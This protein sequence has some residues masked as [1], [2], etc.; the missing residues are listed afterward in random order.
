MIGGFITINRK[1]TEWQWYKYPVHSRLFIHCLLKANF[2][3]NKLG[4]KIIKRGSFVTSCEILA[5]ELGYTKKTVL[6]A[7]VDLEVSGELK[8][9]TCNKGTTITIC[10]YSDYQEGGV[11]ITPQSTPQSTPPRK[12]QVPTNNNVNKE[13]KKTKEYNKNFIALFKDEEIISW[14]KETG[15]KKIHDALLD[16]YNNDFL[17]E[18][19]A[20]A[21]Y[22]QLE[23]KKRKAGTFLKGWCERSNN[24]N[25]HDAEKRLKEFDE[26]LIR[27]LDSGGFNVCE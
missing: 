22:W 27:K 13:T 3:D 20:N 7:L 21:Y 26:E 6:R 10:N 5:N 2:K 25:K 24:P 19:I 12:R 17:I 8:R 1:I 4:R 16:K 23:N 15:N 11:N 9:K 14:L 18:E